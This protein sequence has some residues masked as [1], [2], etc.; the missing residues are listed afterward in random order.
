MIKKLNGYLITKKLRHTHL[1]K[2]RSFSSAKVYYMYDHIKP[3]IRDFNPEY[4]IFHT[5]ASVLNSGKLLARSCYHTEYLQKHN[6][7]FHF[8]N[9]RRQT[10]QQG[11]RNEQ[12]T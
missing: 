9:L 6:H 7:S 3:T 2:V 10:E 11:E 4:V 12:P 8:C 5:G 1:I